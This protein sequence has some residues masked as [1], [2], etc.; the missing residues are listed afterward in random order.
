MTS[1]GSHIDRTAVV[2]PQAVIGRDVTIGPYCVIGPHVSIEEGCRLEAHVHVSGHTSIGA[3]T[4]IFPFAA[5]GGTPQSTGYRGGPTRLTIGPHCIIRES[6][7]MSC[8][9][10]DGGG[11]T[12]V[13]AHGFFMAY[14]H[15]AH[16]CRVGHHVVFANSATLAGHCVVGDYVVIGGLTAVHQFSWIGAHAMISGITGIRGDVIPFGRAAGSSARLSGINAVGMQRRQFSRDSIRAVRSAYRML[17]LSEGQL[18]SRVEAVEKTYGSDAAV[19]MILDFIRAPR[20]RPL[21]AAR[22]SGDRSED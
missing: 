1:G 3:Q 4:H 21:C 2:D 22:G 15:V 20:K 18:A 5:I 7:T 17:F 9:T 16:D 8:G 10:E 11:V 13:G 14:S 12:E 19:A 6:V